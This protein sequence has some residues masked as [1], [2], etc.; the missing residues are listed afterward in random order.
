MHDMYNQ[1]RVGI[2][3][4]IDFSMYL[5]ILLD[6]IKRFGRVVFVIKCF[7]YFAF[8]SGLT[9]KK[10]VQIKT[11]VVLVVSILIQSIRNTLAFVINE[12]IH[13]FNLEKFLTR[14]GNHVRND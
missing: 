3:L 14:V 8:D 9:V 1:N 12:I 5:L 13:H 4:L 2:S 10:V 11:G 6:E 7:I